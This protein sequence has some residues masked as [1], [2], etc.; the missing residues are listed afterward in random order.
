MVEIMEA[1]TRRQ[2]QHEHEHD[3]LGSDG[4][5]MGGDALNGAGAGTGLAEGEGKGWDDAL[6]L[7][8][9]SGSPAK[10]IM[11]CAIAL[12]ALM[13]GSPVEYVSHRQTRAAGGPEVFCNPACPRCACERGNERRVRLV[14]RSYHHGCLD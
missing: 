1:L 7:R 13:R 2:L 11:W 12:G 5:T 14:L 4:F 6:V 8:D 9:V 3:D 10:C